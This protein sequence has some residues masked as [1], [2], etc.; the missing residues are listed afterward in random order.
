MPDALAKTIPI[1][2]TIMNRLTFESDETTYPLQAPMD[3][4][5]GSEYTQIEAK[6]DGFVD[7]AKVPFQCR[8]YLH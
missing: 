7:D 3:V 4:V 6:L 2:C 8:A 5:S 1:W